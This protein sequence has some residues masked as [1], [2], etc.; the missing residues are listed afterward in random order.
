MTANNHDLLWRVA[1]DAINELFNDTSV[2]T[3]ETK[4]DLQA[5]QDEIDCLLDSMDL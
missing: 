3:Q 2:S 1:L 4:Q 5:L